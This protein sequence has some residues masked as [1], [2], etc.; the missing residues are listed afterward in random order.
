[1]ALL[2]GG[3]IEVYQLSNG[4]QTITQTGS[5]AVG[6]GA[7]AAMGSY[8]YIQRNPR[9]V[10]LHYTPGQTDDGAVQDSSIPSSVPP[11]ETL[12]AE[13]T[14]TNTGSTNWYEWASSL[15]I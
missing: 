14:M 10:V 8:L 4:D 3:V 1:F 9:S 7:M 13:I 2:S 15:A 11:G 12:P 5:Y 6:G